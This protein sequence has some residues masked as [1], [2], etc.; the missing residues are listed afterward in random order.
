[1]YW[2]LFEGLEYKQELQIF[3]NL[4]FAFSFIDL[5]EVLPKVCSMDP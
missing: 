3:F 5:K 2:W 4:C 1:M